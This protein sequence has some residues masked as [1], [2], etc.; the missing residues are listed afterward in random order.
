MQ[1]GKNL[2]P[3]HNPL[4]DE[5]KVIDG[6]HEDVLA[7]P[8]GQSSQG[9]GQASASGCSGISKTAPPLTSALLPP[10]PLTATPPFTGQRAGNCSSSIFIHCDFLP[11]LVFMA[12]L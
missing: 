12:I 4:I 1:L 11:P 10:S 9:N 6:E 2:I 5:K 8:Q 7:G 3:K